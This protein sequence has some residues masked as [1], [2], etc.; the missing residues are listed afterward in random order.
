MHDE[1]AV[2][3]GDLL[4]FAAHLRKPAD[5]PQPISRGANWNVDDEKKNC[6]NF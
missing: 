2:L 3:E 5:F 4:V 6:M 1:V